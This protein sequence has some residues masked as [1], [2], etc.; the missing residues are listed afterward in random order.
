[1]D[2]LLGNYFVLVSLL[3]KDLFKDISQ[4]LDYD[5]ES[6]FSE[7]TTQIRDY[8]LSMT[9]DKRAIAVGTD[10]H[11]LQP[12]LFHEPQNGYKQILYLHT[13]YYPL[14]IAN[15]KR[16]KNVLIKGPD[17]RF[18]VI[19]ALTKYNCNFTFINDKYLNVFEKFILQ[20]PEYTYDIEYKVLDRQDISLY[21]KEKFDF[22]LCSGPYLLWEENSIDEYI[23]MLEN[24]GVM[25]IVDTND[26]SS[27]YGE[28]YECWPSYALCE[29]ID[30][31]EN[32]SSY[33]I[34][35]GGGINIIVKN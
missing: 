32:I 31:F 6:V 21:D 24:N 4:D 11:V 34:P 12:E 27:L 33:H 5:Y 9:L 8:Y 15:I 10:A 20:H 13:D 26:G 29:V 30:R 17:T 25:M 1:M 22:I 23:N 7:T 16:P 28:D 18:N 19:A 35:Y 3:T 14:M 2:K